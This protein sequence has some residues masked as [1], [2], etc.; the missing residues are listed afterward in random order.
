[1]ALASSS[2]FV[3]QL[4]EI[5]FTKND[6]QYHPLRLLLTRVRKGKRRPH[7]RVRWQP[8]LNLRKTKKPKLLRTFGSSGTIGF[9]L[10]KR[11]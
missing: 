7:P 3:R 10:N 5:L 1:M 4:T 6:A 2:I 9:L 11:S 8:N